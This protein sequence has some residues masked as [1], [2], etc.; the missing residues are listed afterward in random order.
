MVPYT[1]GGAL[2][3]SNNGVQKS[4]ITAQM[5]RHLRLLLL[6]VQC[7]SGN[8]VTVPRKGFKPAQPFARFFEINVIQFLAN[9]CLERI[10]R[11]DPTLPGNDLNSERQVI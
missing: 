10:A 3:N 4:R 2:C 7:P 5:L 6:C 11:T 1:I 9:A 8:N